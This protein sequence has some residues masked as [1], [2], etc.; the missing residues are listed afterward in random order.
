[1]VKAFTCRVDVVIYGL[2]TIDYYNAVGHYIKST[3]CM[4]DNGPISY[5]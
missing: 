1:M 5:I 3:T 2:Y 4:I